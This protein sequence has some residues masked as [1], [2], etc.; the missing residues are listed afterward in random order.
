MQVLV[1]AYC[2]TPWATSSPQS[3][4]LS[5][6]TAEDATA[7]LAAVAAPDVAASP[8]LTLIASMVPLCL[9]LS[10]LRRIC[11]PQHKSQLSQVVT[12]FTRAAP[13][14][15]AIL[16]HS[17]IADASRLNDRKGYHLRAPQAAVPAPSADSSATGKTLFGIPRPSLRAALATAASTAAS[18][19][20]AGIRSQAALFATTGSALLPQLH[21]TSMAKAGDTGTI[22]TD[23]STYDWLAGLADALSLSRS[24]T[25]AQAS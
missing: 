3:L 9:P 16:A 7:V 23:V 8:R 12:A 18:A 17:V 4:H 22:I 21:S 20:V 24:L 10:V 15:R 6:S 5:D 1:N 25:A 11:Q 14:L 19:A 13:V 2:H